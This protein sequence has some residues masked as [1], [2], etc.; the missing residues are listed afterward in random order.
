MFMKIKIT[1]DSASDMSK[2]LLEKYNI[3]VMPIPVILGDKQCKD[4]VD[5]TVQDLYDYIDKT[6]Q[7]PKTASYN[8]VEAE[9]FFRRELASDG[10][11][12]A[13]IH[14]GLSSGLS[15]VCQNAMIASGEF[16]NRVYVVDTLSLST[17][18]ALQA[19]RAAE[20]A[21]QGLTAAKI[22]EDIMAARRDIQVSFVVDKLKMLHKGGRCSALAVFG[23]NLLNIKP[24]IKMSNG[25]LGVGQK[26]RGKY[27]ECVQKYVEATLSANPNY[28]RK[29]VFI[30]HTE[31]SAEIVDAVKSQLEGKF[32]EIIE[33][34]AGCTITVHCGKNT[35]GILFYNKPSVEEE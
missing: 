5:V 6:G 19:I 3:S 12:D 35:L 25:K 1:V 31:T 20:L 8:P 33:T 17:G 21:S 7:L 14:F 2:E 4:S 23:A 28:D 32:D 16:D 27:L 10:G 30:T 11:Y 34:E 9:E 15:S 13:L 29:R 26:F 22:F 18:I 24:S